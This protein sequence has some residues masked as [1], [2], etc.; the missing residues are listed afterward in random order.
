MKTLVK[1]NQRK[2]TLHKKKYSKL[3]LLLFRKSVRCGYHSVSTLR[4]RLEA[5]MRG[6]TS[7]RSLKPSQKRSPDLPQAKED[8]SG[9][10]EVLRTGCFSGI[11]LWKTV[12]TEKCSES[13]CMRIPRA[14]LLCK[15]EISKY[16]W[17]SFNR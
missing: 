13:R 7:R 9:K 8:N 11:Y 5:K 10:Y 4:S 1:P 12:S 14:L 16:Q 3:N 17:P 6:M 15:K 2:C